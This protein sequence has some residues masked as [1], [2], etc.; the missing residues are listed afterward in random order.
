MKVYFSN[1]I[2]RIFSYSKKLDDITLIADKFWVIIDDINTTKSV[3]VFRNS[4]ELILSQNG[5]VKKGSWDYL[6]NNS[7][8]IDVDS[9]SYLLKHAFLDENILVL[10][11]DNENNYVFFI[12]ENKFEFGI[13]SLEEINQYLEN[14]YLNNQ[15]FK[16]G[17]NSDIEF[18]DGYFHKKINTD[19]GII[20][21]RTKLSE[22]F[23]IGDLVYSHNGTTVQD[24][25]YSIGW[26]NSILVWEGKIL[27]L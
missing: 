17:K 3:Y 13:N 4:K 7:I 12:N 26:F 10:K 16:S 5:K 9:E 6:G 1:I 20:I 25:R 18:I 19:K 2:P 24:G 21:I 22:G 15:D 14:K 8:I 27:K 11:I 23:T